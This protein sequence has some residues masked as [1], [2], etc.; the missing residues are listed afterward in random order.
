M[1]TFVLVTAEELSILVCILFLAKPLYSVLV[2][3]EELIILVY[4]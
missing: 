2:I 1:F 4:I 3:A